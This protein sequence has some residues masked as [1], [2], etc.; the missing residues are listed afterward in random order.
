MAVQ[1][2]CSAVGH[3]AFIWLV[4]TVRMPITNKVSGDTSAIC[5]AKEAVQ[6]RWRHCRRFVCEGNTDTSSN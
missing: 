3:S 1:T 5:A 2:T 4:T 6:A